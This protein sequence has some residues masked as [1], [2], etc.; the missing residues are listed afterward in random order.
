MY[1]GQESKVQIFQETE[2][3]TL[4]DKV[5][6]WLSEMFRKHGAE[7]QNPDIKMI[8]APGVQDRFCAIVSYSLRVY[9]CDMF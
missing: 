6:A 9:G 1:V 2:V 8:V 7:F 3:Q 5:N 4:Q